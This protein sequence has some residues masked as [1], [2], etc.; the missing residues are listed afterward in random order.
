M[1]DPDGDVT[2]DQHDT[3]DDDIPEGAV[4]TQEL[5]RSERTKKP[6][7]WNSDYVMNQQ[8]VRDVPDWR[9][10]ADYLKSLLSVSSN[11]LM[12]IDRSEVSKALLKIITGKQ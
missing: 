5:R 4:G 11:D 1:I 3:G 6:P 12:C 7:A 8:I 2:V 10:R 9:K